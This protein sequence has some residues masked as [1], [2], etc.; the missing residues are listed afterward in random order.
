MSD[1]PPD[2][3]PD[4]VVNDVVKN[5]ELVKRWVSDPDFRHG[6]LSDEDPAKFA[7]EADESFVL[8]HKTAEWLKELVEH[9]SP[10]SLVAELDVVAF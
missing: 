6:L 3:I 2:D 8:S 9:R 10:A 5:P 4:Y 1:S 7:Q